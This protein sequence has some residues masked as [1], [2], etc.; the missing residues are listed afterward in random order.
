M[1]NKEFLS[2]PVS[3]NDSRSVRRRRK[4]LPA[5]TADVSVC[6]HL[7][8]AGWRSG[9]SSW[10]SKYVIPTTLTT[11]RLKG[12]TCVEWERRLRASSRA[13]A[14]PRPFQT[15][16]RQHEPLRPALPGP[17]RLLSSTLE[18]P[19]T[20]MQFTHQT[21]RARQVTC[22]QLHVNVS[23]PWVPYHR[24]PDFE[25]AETV[26][27]S[28]PADNV[29]NVTRRTGERGPCRASSRHKMRANPQS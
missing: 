1:S 23:L 18:T 13:S 12:H 17:G 28:L 16:E 2:E 24:D 26:P 9:C 15:D 14:S 8:T 25:N 11:R 27:Q 10:G 3:G 5:G 7:S 22:L 21:R 6:S 4:E 19:F 29:L 20:H